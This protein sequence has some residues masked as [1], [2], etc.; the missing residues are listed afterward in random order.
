MFGQS[1]QA[2]GCWLLVWKQWNAL[3][4]TRP[5]WR[6]LSMI[7]GEEEEEEKA[8]GSWKV[9]EGSEIGE[10]WKDRGS[11]RG[12]KQERKKG[13]RRVGG[14][15]KI[16]TRER[17]C[18][19]EGG[20]REDDVGGPWGGRRGE[21]SNTVYPALILA[22]VFVCVCVSGHPAPVAVR[23][24]SILLSPSLFSPPP[25]LVEPRLPPRIFSNC[26]VHH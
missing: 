7:I 14:T 12:E 9:K 18:I 17:D 19:K 10:W 15:R 23:H 16:K 4:R 1:C 25:I 22:S 21:R 13:K 8:R 11:E 26:I 24:F 3:I 6:G 5:K 2:R 20:E